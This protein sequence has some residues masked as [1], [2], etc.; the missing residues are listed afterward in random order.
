MLHLDII[1]STGHR[2]A[3]VTGAE[4]FVIGRSAECQL[5][6]NDAQVSR[7]HC[8]LRRANGGW[9]VRDCGS[10]FGTFL[11]EERIEDAPL[12]PGD[13]LRLGQTEIRVSDQPASQTGSAAFDFRQMSALL[14]SLRALGSTHVLDEVLAIVIDSALDVT[15]AERGFIL[16][17]DADGTLE[18]TLARQRGG[19]SVPNAQTSH[20]IPDQVFATGEDAVVADLQDDE[21]AVAHMGTIALGIRHVVCTP[22]TVA[23][24]GEAGTVRRIGVLYLDGRDRGHLQQ[25]ATL[26]AIAAQ[27]AVVIEN[28]RLYRQVL[29]REKTAQELRLAARI[30]QALLPPPHY[31]GAMV[32]LAAKST[33]CLDVGGDFFDYGA[34]EGHVSFVLGDVA[35]KGTSAAL[36]TAVIQ[37][38]FAAEADSRDTPDTVLT[39]VNRSLCRRAIEA[40]FVTAFYGQVEAGGLRY[41]NAGHNAP[42][43]FTRAGVQRLDTGGLIMGLF[44]SAS[45]ASA[46]VPVAA[47]DV[48]VVFSDGVTEAVNPAGDEWGDVRL[49]ECLEA[50]RTQPVSEILTS[51]ERAVRRFCGAEPTR[52]DV[53]VMVVRIR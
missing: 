7:R 52:D 46:T 17:A 38:L 20:R 48:L 21:H 16:L 35:G 5:Q 47:G 23:D 37:G 8:E 49:A 28:A 43:L 42:F 34:R 32:E 4:P 14:A 36:L 29:E 40:R 30:Q 12:T 2:T 9:S 45:Y 39:R 19:R 44:E 13:R 25:L 27:A 3:S 6:L 22:L 10:R 41:C 18:L 51:V 50:V 53:T 31:D 1:E 26:R 24:Y 33:P 15:G 11:N